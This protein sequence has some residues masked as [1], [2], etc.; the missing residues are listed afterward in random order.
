MGRAAK[1]VGFIGA[2]L[3]VAVLVVLAAP[4][5]NFTDTVSLLLAGALAAAGAVIGIRRTRNAGRFDLFH[6]LLFPSLYVAVAC[7]APALWLYGAGRELG[8][9]SPRLMATNTPILMAL[10]AAGFTLGCM[11]KVKSTGSSGKPIDPRV[12]GMAGRLLLAVPLL[13]AAR[14]LAAG[15]VTSRGQGQ[16][17]FNFIDVLNAAGMIAAPAGVAMILAS[18]HQLERRLLS[19]FDGA[20]ILTLIVLLGL[21]GRRGAAVGVM[22]VLLFFATRRR[23]MNVRAILGFVAMAVFAYAVVVFR[24][25]A[26]GGRTTLST[27]GVLLRDLGSVAFTTGATALAL[28]PGQA[29]H[30][31]SILAGLLRQLPSPVANSILGTPDDTGAYVFRSMTGL[32]NNSTGYGFSIP[33]E[34]VLNFGTVG[35][36]AVPFVAGL[37]L[38]WMYARFDALGSR[39][40]ALIYPVAVGTIPFAWRSDTLGAV[41]GVFYP[42]LILFMTIVFARTAATANARFGRHRVRD[43]RKEPAQ[44][45]L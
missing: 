5:V 43:P 41:K 33:A 19:L 31:S 44:A 15:I 4:T 36:F 16:S 25:T 14:D 2:G 45:S 18:R 40:L 37:L 21:N 30:G 34:G 35:A 22:V 38:T 27:V 29:L 12:L 24:T 3:L 26:T 11:V 17:S 23:G 13:L 6:P 10:A 9:I 1:G 20:M 8:Y 28:E 7:L 32:G 42:A 39:A